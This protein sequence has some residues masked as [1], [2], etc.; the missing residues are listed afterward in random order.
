MP[1]A[2][3][4][5]ALW[6]DP[7]KVLDAVGLKPGMEVVDLCSGDGLVYVADRENRAPRSCHRY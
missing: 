3:W 6:P 1:T 4:W 7:V 2:G 5:E